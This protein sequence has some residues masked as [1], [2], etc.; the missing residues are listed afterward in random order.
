MATVDQ[1]HQKMNYSKMIT[2]KRLGFGFN[3]DDV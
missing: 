2:G 3:T 1:M